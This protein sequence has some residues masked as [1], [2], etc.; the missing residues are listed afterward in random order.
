MKLFR[1]RVY[2]ELDMIQSFE[3]KIQRT[4]YFQ[5]ILPVSCYSRILKL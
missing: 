2:L 5:K 1:A 4:K 3:F